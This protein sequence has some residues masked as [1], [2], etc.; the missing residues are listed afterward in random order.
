MKTMLKVLSLAAILAA[1]APLAMA[2][3]ISG[4]INAGGNDTFNN[5]T[6]TFA[7]NT[8]TTLNEYVT[9]NSE[10]NGTAVSQFTAI[11]FLLGTATYTPGGSFNPA[12]PFASVQISPGNTLFFSV[13][14]ET[15]TYVA[16]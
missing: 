7:P 15:P 13:S 1:S 11:D 12:V 8:S 3:S 6:I 10:I 2:D 16:G 14:S 9:G 4:N 5:T